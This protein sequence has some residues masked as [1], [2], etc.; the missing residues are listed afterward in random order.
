MNST[1]I[2]R[3]KSA[4]RGISH[5]RALALLSQVRGMD[6]AEEIHMLLRNTLHELGLGQL[7]RPMIPEC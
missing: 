6:D 3:V 7:S 5:V 2:P 1:N 4:I